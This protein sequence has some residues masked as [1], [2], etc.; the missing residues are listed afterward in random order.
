MRFVIFGAGAVGSTVGAHLS[1]AGTDVLLIGDPPHIEKIQTNGL[2]MS[3]KYGEFVTTPPACSALNDWQF[4]PDDIVFLCVK[5]YDTPVAL[6]QMRAKV[7]PDTPIF[8]LQNTMTNEELAV[9]H[10]SHVYGAALH[11]GARFIFPGEVGHLGGNSLVIGRYPNGLDE[12]AE[13]V[14]T[15]LQAANMGGTLTDDILACKWAK[16]CI[17][18]MNAP[19]AILDRSGPELLNDPDSRR[20]CG[21][22]LAEA[23]HVLARAEIKLKTL[24]G[25][26]PLP[27]MVTNLGR[28]DFTPQSLPDRSTHVF[29]SMWQDVF[30]RRGRTEACYLNGRVHEMGQQL[31][32]ATPINTLLAQVADT[33]AE[34]RELP[35]TYTLSDLRHML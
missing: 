29:P 1:K 8:C 18:L 10:F 13:Q 9:E 22:M 30:C 35:G 26:Q 25:D 16:F 21:A 15:A 3:G 14:V 6:E 17:N 34:R 5:T 31:G 11:L 2:K 28:T 23:Q 7:S 20:L 4:Q 27:D 19:A 24:P 12:T 32:I 33:M